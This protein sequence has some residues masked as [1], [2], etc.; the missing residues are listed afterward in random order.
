MC[1]HPCSHWHRLRHPQSRPSHARNCPDPSPAPRCPPPLPP[2]P[3]RPL[4]TKP[5]PRSHR[6]LTRGRTHS[7][8]HPQDHRDQNRFRQLHHYDCL[9]LHPPPLASASEPTAT[10]PWPSRSSSR[11][12]GAA[13]TSWRSPCLWTRDSH[14]AQTCILPRPYTWACPAVLRALSPSLPTGTSIEPAAPTSWPGQSAPTARRCTAPALAPP[15]SCTRDGDGRTCPSGPTRCSLRCRSSRRTWTGLLACRERSQESAFCVP[16]Q[17]LR[18]GRGVH[19][20]ALPPLPASVARP[21]FSIRPRSSARRCRKTPPC[22]PPPSSSSLTR[23]AC[24]SSTAPCARRKARFP[25]LAWNRTRTGVASW[26]GGRCTPPSHA[27]AI[28]RPPLLPRLWRGCAVRNGRRAER[29]R[30]WKLDLLLYRLSTIPVPDPDPRQPAQNHRRAPALRGHTLFPGHTLP[31]LGNVSTELELQLHLS[32][33]QPQQPERLDPGLRCSAL[34][35][36]L[37]RQLARQTALRSK[38]LQP[39]ERHLARTAR[40][41]SVYNSLVEPEEHLQPRLPSQSL[42]CTGQ[43]AGVLQLE[44][45]AS[46]AARDACQLPRVLA[47]ATQQVSAGDACK[48]V[49]SSIILIRADSALQRSATRVGGVGCMAS[50]ATGEAPAVA[51]K[52][53]SHLNHNLPLL[54]C[55]GHLAV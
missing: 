54:F 11:T 1:R 52:A 36:L 26:P 35:H 50:P 46:I 53:P 23:P 22:P 17:G 12:Q 39:A 55:R 13:R 33:G 4:G 37:H 43:E 28:A 38:Y 51:N 7:R 31:Q 49:R 5:P 30:I 45:S 10:S 44:V 40:D 42:D 3:P 19:A 2:I 34:E 21:F 16:W 9:C 29:L 20:P 41:Q 48:V 24:V 6:I 15:L 27:R 8:P 47:V 32:P 14:E 18:C 25:A